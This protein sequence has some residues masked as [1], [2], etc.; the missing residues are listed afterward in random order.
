MRPPSAI[1]RSARGRSRRVA[2]GASPASRAR[3]G[4]VTTLPPTSDLISLNSFMASIRPTTAPAPISSPS[5]TYGRA[6]GDGEAYQTP[7][8]G[9]VTKRIPGAGSPY[10]VS[11]PAAAAGAGT[12]TL[13]TGAGPAGCGGVRPDQPDDQARPPR[14]PAR[15][16]PL[17]SKAGR[18]E[19][20][21]RQHRLAR[22]SLGVIGVVIPPE[23]EGGVVPAEAERVAH[24]RV[25][26]APRAPR[27]A[28]SR[29][30]SPGS[31]ILVVDRRRHDPVSIA[32]MQAIA[33]MPP[34]APS[35]WPVMLLVLLT[36]TPVGAA[37]RRPS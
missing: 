26:R 9:A 13:A 17:A 14:P 11:A 35:R 16:G 25:D 36:G 21:G 28:R 22:S 1:V 23:D 18:Q 10:G 3:P 2:A 5:C 4:R 30:R 34:P 37:R 19:V 29:G 33:S 20:D 27:S 8:S 7:V 31:G 15:P 6:P 24:G 32:R 12:P